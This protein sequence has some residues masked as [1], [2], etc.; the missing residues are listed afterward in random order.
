MTTIARTFSFDRKTSKRLNKIHIAEK[1]RPFSHILRDALE[2][3]E[4]NHHPHLEKEMADEQNTA[5]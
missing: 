4:G 5:R 1:K 3:Y 2:E